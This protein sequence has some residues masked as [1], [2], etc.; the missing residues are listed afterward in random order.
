MDINQIIQAL[1]SSEALSGIAGAASVDLEDAK[2]VIENA[3]SPMIRGAFGSADLSK[4]KTLLE[5][6]SGSFGDAVK[7]IDLKEGAKLLSELL[8]SKESATVSEISRESGVEE[9]KTKNIL[10]AAAP[11]VANILG[12]ELKDGDIGALAVSLMKNISF[13][14][15]FGGLFG[16]K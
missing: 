14:D 7:K 10:S 16:M 12:T 11:L 5:G 9:G 2:S 3:V 13:T 6:F 4:L 15:L 1:T 8:G